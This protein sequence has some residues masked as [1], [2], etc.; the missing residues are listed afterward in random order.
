MATL[1][2]VESRWIDIGDCLCVPGETMRHI[3]TQHSADSV[4]C[5]KE[6]LLYV[7]SLH[8]YPGWRVIIHALYRIEEHQVAT[9]IEEYGEPVAGMFPKS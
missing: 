6:V 5:L 9:R 1:K 3:R 4:Q 2:G 7:L 8:P